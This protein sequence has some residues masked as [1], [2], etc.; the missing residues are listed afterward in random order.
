MDD[1][2]L[3]LKYP[4]IQKQLPGEA[5]PLQGKFQV[6]QM[7]VRGEP[8][9]R[10]ENFNLIRH[11]QFPKGFGGIQS[12]NISIQKKEEIQPADLRAYQLK[13]GPEKRQI[14]FPN[15]N[16][17]VQAK[18]T[19]PFNL[20]KKY[21][22][23]FG[24]IY[25]E[26]KGLDDPSYQIYVYDKVRAIYNEMVAKGS[27]YWDMLQDANNKYQGKGKEELVKKLAAKRKT[28]DARFAKNYVTKTR[29][30][31]D[32]KNQALYSSGLAFEGGTVDPEKDIP[33]DNSADFNDNSITALHN[34]AERDMAR[35]ADKKLGGSK[36]YETRGLPNSEILW[37]QY[38]AAAEN[39]FW[40][41]KQSRA[42]ELVKAL[43]IIKRRQVQP[44]STLAT[45]MFALPDN[46]LNFDLA[47]S[48]LA[49]T[50][51]FKALL[52]TPNCSGAAFLLA[53]HIDELDNKSITEIELLGGEDV[54]L[55]IKLG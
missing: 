45:V 26:Y 21:A 27:G 24:F 46:K 7:Q 16:N 4:G 12:S 3:Q 54:N 20:S 22:A 39:Q 36:D 32:Y 25:S 5:I 18:K 52:G 23:R 35:E 19:G 1:T 33:Y 49:G 28:Y 29:E 9:R 48:W 55:D 17:P 30:I 15:D 41:Y 53:D 38:K 37:Q 40:F 31:G 2:S 11:K 51:E 6:L 10:Q 14:A 42:Q 44:I 47:H 8:V 34:Y 43:S 50:E 13:L